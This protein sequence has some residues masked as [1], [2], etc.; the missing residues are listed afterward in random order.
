MEQLVV[1]L[2]VPN[3]RT[4]FNR[5]VYWL[6]LCC[7]CQNVEISEHRRGNTR[8]TLEVNRARVPAA[9]ARRRAHFRAG[10]QPATVSV[11][12]ANNNNTTTNVAVWIE[13]I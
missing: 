4:I 3:V 12:W 5:A 1:S 7:R 9:G 6:S 11:A 2:L 10:H 8:I 13:D